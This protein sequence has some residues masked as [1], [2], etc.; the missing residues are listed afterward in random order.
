MDVRP[1]ECERHLVLTS[2]RCGTDPNVKPAIKVHVMQLRQKSDPMKFG[3]MA[4]P[5]EGEHQG[6][7]EYVQAV[8]C[9]K[10]KATGKSQYRE[11][12]ATGIGNPAGEPRL[13]RLDR[14][15]RTIVRTSATTP[16]RRGTRLRS[17]TKARGRGEAKRVTYGVAEENIDDAGSEIVQ[18]LFVIMI[19][20]RWRKSG[21]LV[22]GRTVRKPRTTPARVR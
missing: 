1:V 19:S 21:K 20:L 9:S 5:A 10:G 8:G 3:E 22:L 4:Y 13:E 14:N 15:S 12:E 18:N 2:S 6:Y 17:V 7:W 16:G 11:K